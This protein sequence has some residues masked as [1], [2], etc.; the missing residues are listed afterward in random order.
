MIKMFYLYKPPVSLASLPKP[1]PS[2][3]LTSDLLS[4]SNLQFEPLRWL[5][6]SDLALMLNAAEHR[7]ALKVR[8]IVRDLSLRLTHK[9]L[10]I[11]TSYII[12]L[13]RRRLR[14]RAPFSVARY[15]SR[16]LFISSDSISK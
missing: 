15:A 13:Q 2:A 1:E 10:A 11:T 14:S 3:N 5:G 6:T 4:S 16:M 7:A 12:E 9:D 8:L